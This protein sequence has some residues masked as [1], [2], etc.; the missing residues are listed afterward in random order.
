MH[1][2]N[3]LHRKRHSRPELLIIDSRGNE[4]PGLAGSSTGLDGDFL[5][6][7]FPMPVGIDY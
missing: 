3:T 2:I 1:M 5:I 4:F 6:C 7:G